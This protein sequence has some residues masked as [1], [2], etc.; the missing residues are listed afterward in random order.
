VIISCQVFHP[1]LNEISISPIKLSFRQ[2]LSRN[3]IILNGQYIRKAAVI[4]M[5]GDVLQLPNSLSENHFFISKRHI[6]NRVS[7]HLSAL[8]ERIYRKTLSFRSHAAIAP[9]AKSIPI[10]Q[11]LVGCPSN[12]TIDSRTL[13]VIS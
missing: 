12:L 9:C 8:L 1:Y 4:L 2:D 3:G 5:H 7:V 10:I 6:L 13:E 11:I